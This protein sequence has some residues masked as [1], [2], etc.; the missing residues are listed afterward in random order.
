VLEPYI[1][2]GLVTLHDWREHPGQRGAYDHCV[3][4]HEGDSRWIAFIDADEFLFSPLG[5]PLPEILPDYEEA[6]AVGVSW[7][8]FG[9]SGHKTRPSG[10][11]TESYT[12]RSTSKANNFLKCIVDPTRTER[13]VS[14]HA[15]LYRDGL[16]VDEDHEPIPAKRGRSNTPTPSRARLRINHYT[17]KSEEEWRAKLAGDGAFY[18]RPRQTYM[19]ELPNLDFNDEADDTIQVYLPTLRA[20]MVDSAA[21]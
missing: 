21:A 7:I 20:A 4:E 11:V 17:T 9:T 12:L 18:G 10:L 16:A 14:P 2:A 15:F 6:P 3:R 5:V 19:P 13:C 8:L 1:E